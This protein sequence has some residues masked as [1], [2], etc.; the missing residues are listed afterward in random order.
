MQL[1]HLSSGETDQQ[2]TAEVMGIPSS[3]GVVVV[4]GR[5]NP[6]TT[7]HQKLLK[8]AGT[9]ASRLGYD[10]KIYPSRS[11]DAKK[12]PLHLEQR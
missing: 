5:F 6:P 8:S 2:Q 4:F 3:E 10:F 9:E 12:N 7:G 11:V 1:N